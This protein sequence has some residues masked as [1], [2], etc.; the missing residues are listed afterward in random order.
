[1]RDLFLK[2]G[3]ESYATS[4]QEFTRIVQRDVAKWAKVV[5]ASGATPD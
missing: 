3:A 4:P 1:V 2:Q 5:K